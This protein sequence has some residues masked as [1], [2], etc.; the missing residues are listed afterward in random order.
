MAKNGRM[1]VDVKFLK[2]PVVAKPVLRIGTEDFFEHEETPSGT[3]SFNEPWDDPGEDI[4]GY[5]YYTPGNMRAR[6]RALKKMVAGLRKQ[7][8]AMT[9]ALDAFEKENFNGK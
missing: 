7:V 2:P 1:I 6:R 3:F 5:A 4:I 9:I 8:A